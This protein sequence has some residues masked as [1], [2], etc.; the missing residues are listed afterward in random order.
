[1][2]RYLAHPVPELSHRSSFEGW[3]PDEAEGAEASRVGLQLLDS[4]AV[5][6]ANAY[7]VLAK[8][9]H[10]RAVSDVHARL[11]YATD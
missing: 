6:S 2:R 8:E 10:T 3:S 9:A 4:I 7:R 1:M 11:D 5:D